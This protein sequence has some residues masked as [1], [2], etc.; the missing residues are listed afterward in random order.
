MLGL[1][2]ACVR[3][4]VRACSFVKLIMGAIA[5]IPV[6][7]VGGGATLKKS[8]KSRFREFLGG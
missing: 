2:R 7:T 4:C 5:T 3:A 1:C 6:Y 8:K